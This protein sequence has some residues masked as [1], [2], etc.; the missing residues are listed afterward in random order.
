MLVGLQDEVH[1]VRVLWPSTVARLDETWKEHAAILA[2]LKAHDPGAAERCMREHL[3]RARSSTVKGILPRHSEHSS[4]PSIRPLARR[5]IAS[6]P[7]R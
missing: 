5:S 2:A 1:R 7:T 4:R 6:I 3:E